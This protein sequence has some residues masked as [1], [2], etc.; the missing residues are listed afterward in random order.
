MRRITRKDLSPTAPR[1]S[2]GSEPILKGSCV[3]LSDDSQPGYGQVTAV[4]H[5]PV[6]IEVRMVRRWGEHAK[7]ELFQ[8][9]ELRVI[10]DLIHTIQFLGLSHRELEEKTKHLVC[11]E[12]NSIKDE[13][14]WEY[15]SHA[16]KPESEAGD[17]S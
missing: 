13:G 15:C 11:G 8:P 17:E 5:R 2:N 9:H 12:C 4:Y 10:P 3:K 7:I 16:A 1:D 6:W 14:H